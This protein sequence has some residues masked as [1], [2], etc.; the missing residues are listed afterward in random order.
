V[1]RKQTTPIALVILIAVQ[2]V[3]AAFFVAD[4]VADWREAQ[5]Y[6][7]AEFRLHLPIEAVATLALLAAVALELHFL[8]GLMR[9]NAE[10]ERSLGIARGAVAEV[11]DAHFSAWGLSP[12]ERDVALFLVKG[13]NT[14]EIA[15]VRGSAEGT[16]KAHLAAIYR[17]SGTRS[18]SDMLSVLIDSLVAGEKGPFAS[19][20]D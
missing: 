5:L 15:E 14:A 16:I 6:P 20:V 1:T 2:V 11:I 12:A 13:L 17:K 9:R 10:L 18:R 4:L 8:R 19:V 7:A 3:C